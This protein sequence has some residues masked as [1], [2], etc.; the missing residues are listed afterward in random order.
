[1]LRKELFDMQIEFK[2][3]H[4]QASLQVESNLAGETGICPYCSKGITVPEKDAATQSDIKEPV[5]KE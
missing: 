4:C 3:P 5:K 2:C 1:M